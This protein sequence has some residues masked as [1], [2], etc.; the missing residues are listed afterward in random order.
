MCYL[1]EHSF[2]IFQQLILHSAS[3][4]CLFIL[5]FSKRKTIG[6]RVLTFEHLNVMDYCPCVNNSVECIPW[7]ESC[8]LTLYRVI[9]Y[10]VSL[11]IP[12]Q[13]ASYQSMVRIC[14]RML[15]LGNWRVTRSGL[16]QL[17]LITADVLEQ[18]KGMLREMQIKETKIKSSEMLFIR[19]HHNNTN[20]VRCF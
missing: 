2:G 1:N 9:V 7:D 6:C 8:G 19:L 17:E 18:K 4:T 20:H 15:Q 14:P 10:S 11:C 3:R 16:H 12:P 13:T 5:F